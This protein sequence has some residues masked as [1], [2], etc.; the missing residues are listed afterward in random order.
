VE[1]RFGES[2]PAYA[3]F[4]CYSTFVRS[5][6][7]CARSDHRSNVERHIPLFI[8]SSVQAIIITD[9]TN[10]SVGTILTFVRVICFAAAIF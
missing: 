1:V 5:S 6:A 9:C 2:G 3:F 10:D 8:S 7:S 4:R